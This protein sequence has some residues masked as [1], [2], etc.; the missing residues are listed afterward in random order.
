MTFQQLQYLLEVRQT[1]SI[2]KAASNLF[3]S[4]SSISA[5]VSSLED[6]LGFAIF[7]RSQKGLVP[8]SDGLRVLQ[9]AERI[10]KTYD[11][12]NHVRDEKLKRLRVSFRSYTPFCNAF[13]RLVAENAHRT[14]IAFSSEALMRDDMIHKLASHE[15]DLSLTAYF[16]PR[17]RLLEDRVIKNGLTYRFLKA[18]PAAVCVGPGH[19]LYNATCVHPRDLEN[20]IIVDGIRQ[21]LV[22]SDYLHGVMCFKPENVVICDG[23]AAQELLRMG[24]AYTI[25]IMPSEYTPADGDLHYIPL[26]GVDH[27]LVL[28]T[29]PDH[30]LSPEANRFLELLDEELD[31]I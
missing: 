28:V 20:D 12:M 5:A 19:R 29:N 24:I 9:Y 27:I 6:E 30:P 16:E 2:S 4:N 7:N 10:C 21:P 23:G 14:D 15:L 11:Q 1:K 17:I 31:K 8:T 22:K 13:A 3:V 25:T 26:E 18:V